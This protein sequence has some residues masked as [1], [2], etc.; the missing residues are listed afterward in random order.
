MSPGINHP[1]PWEQVGIKDVS[2]DKHG[3]ARIKNTSKMNRF[4]I[5]TPQLLF[6]GKLNRGKRYMIPRIQEM[7][8][9]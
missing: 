5:Y 6:L 7:R 1:L 3:N 8:N 9:A 2:Y 4:T